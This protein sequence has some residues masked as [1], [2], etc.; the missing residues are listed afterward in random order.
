M[1]NRISRI[2]TDGIEAIEGDMVKDPDS[3]YNGKRMRNGRKNS[4]S[5]WTYDVTPEL[6]WISTGQQEEGP[7][8]WRS[9]HENMQC[10]G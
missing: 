5:P 3:A 4:G 8:E 10:N 6:L 2:C 1:H 7:N 9:D